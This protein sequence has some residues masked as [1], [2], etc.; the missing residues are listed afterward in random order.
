M[1]EDSFF[2]EP[3]EQSRVKAEI[4]AKYFWAWARVILPSVKR[5]GGRIAYIDLFS[6]P[7]RY[8]DGTKSTPLLILE[9]AIQDVDMRDRLV[10]IFNDASPESAKALQHEINSLPG[11]NILKYPPQV[12]NTEVGEDIVKMFERTRLAP[13]L[14]FMDPWGYKG[15]SLRLINSAIKDWG[16]DCILFFNYNRINM[17]LHNKAV[18]AHMNALFG[19][20]RADRLR[21]ELEPLDVHERMLT[22]IEALIESIGCRFVNFSSSGN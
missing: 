5:R 12:N 6:G 1:S 19:E 15:M 7:G 3:T 10:T 16:S 9:R 21:I 17:G 11:I 20:E 4:V 2:N 13:T 14:F 8:R 18:E 22:I